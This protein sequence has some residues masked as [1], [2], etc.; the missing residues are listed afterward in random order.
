MLPSAVITSDSIDTH[1]SEASCEK[2]RSTLNLWILSNATTTKYEAPET[3]PTTLATLC[4][5]YWS[6]YP[7]QYISPKFSPISY[8]TNFH[9]I[10]SP[11]Y[12]PSRPH[13]HLLRH[14]AFLENLSGTY[15][16]KMRLLLFDSPMPAYP[17]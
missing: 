5:Y 10:F 6:P 4:I 3:T 7:T 2:N 12:F 8:H 15:F 17:L 1:L 14:T 9:H 13:T 11:M 16:S